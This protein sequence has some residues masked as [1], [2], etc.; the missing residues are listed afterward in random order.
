MKVAAKPK[1]TAA[2]KRIAARVKANKNLRLPPFTGKLKCQKCSAVHGK[3]KRG[4]GTHV[5]YVYVNG[6]TNQQE[7]RCFKHL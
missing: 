3:P 4:G 7:V 1:A 2:D 6:K 5:I